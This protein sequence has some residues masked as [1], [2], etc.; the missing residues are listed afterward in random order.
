MPRVKKRDSKRKQVMALFGNV[1]I[2]RAYC[3]YCRHQA[4]VVR[5][6]F[7]CCGARLQHLEPKLFVREA[8]PENVRRLPPKEYR[9]MQ[10]DRQDHRCFY[11]N[12]VFGDHGFRNGTEVTIKLTWDHQVPFAYSQDNRNL[13]FVAAC[14]IC[15][16]TKSA[17]V[18]QTVDEAKAY[19]QL[20]R[21]SKGYDW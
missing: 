16:G 17:M 1:A 4:F 10:L 12:A 6:R 21:K 7:N 15:N 11:C 18:F 14:Q 19:L 13:N 2:P 3:P 9:D 5:G 20:R 8:E